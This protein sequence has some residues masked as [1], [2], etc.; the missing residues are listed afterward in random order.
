MTEPTGIYNWRDG[1]LAQRVQ[2][3]PSSGTPELSRGFSYAFPVSVG[4]A[5][6]APDSIS[7][8]PHS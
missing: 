3:N 4:H 6:I 8:I 7:A 1:V 5:A 2:F